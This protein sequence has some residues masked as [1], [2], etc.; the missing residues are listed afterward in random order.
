LQPAGLSCTQVGSTLVRVSR[1]PAPTLE[2]RIGGQDQAARFTTNGRNLRSI[3]PGMYLLAIADDG[4]LLERLYMTV[5]ELRTGP[6]PSAISA[7]HRYWLAALVREDGPEL[8]QP[9]WL[10]VGS[11]NAAGGAW[12]IDARSLRVLREA[13]AVEE[14]VELRLDTADCNSLVS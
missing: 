1:A 4:R 10:R 14:H 2:M 9:D 3:E 8:P 11:L 13:S 12:L 7:V 5:D 6:P